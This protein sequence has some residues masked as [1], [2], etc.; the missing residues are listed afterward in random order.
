MVS[1]FFAFYLVS[2]TL[3]KRS[4]ME[5]NPNIY[6][7]ISFS[8]PTKKKELFS[9][10]NQNVYIFTPTK[11]WLDSVENRMKN[12]RIKP[13][14][15]KSRKKNNCSCFSIESWRQIY[16]SH[17]FSHRSLPIF[18]IFYFI[19]F[20]VRMIF[21]VALNFNEK[22]CFVVG[23]FWILLSL[24]S[25]IAVR[26]GLGT[27]CS[28]V[29]SNA[30]KWSVDDNKDNQIA[31]QQNLEVK[32]HNGLWQKWKTRATIWKYGKRKGDDKKNTKK[33]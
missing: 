6:I 8:L 7:S 5:L 13:L 20:F 30:V 3:V 19:S 32:T 17:W 31:H 23:F 15:P 29:E 33:F 9:R 16:F 10:C 4:E 14:A 28:F 25:V 26:F 12:E 2:T 24:L 1:C 22:V 11:T 18:F 27:K 21:F